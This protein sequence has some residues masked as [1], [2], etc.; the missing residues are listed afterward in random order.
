MIAQIHTCECLAWCLL[1]FQ[2]WKKSHKHISRLSVQTPSTAL[3]C[4]PLLSLRFRA[5]NIHACSSLHFWPLDRYGIV[6][7]G[8][9]KKLHLGLSRQKRAFRSWEGSEPWRHPPW[10]SY[11]LNY[12]ST[13]WTFGMQQPLPSTA[14]LRNGTPWQLAVC[15]SGLQLQ[16][17]PYTAVTVPS[18]FL[19]EEWEKLLL[20]L[21]KILIR[22]LWFYVFLSCSLL[23]F[24]LEFSSFSLFYFIPL[25]DYQG[26]FSDYSWIFLHF[27]TYLNIYYSSLRVYQ[28]GE[29]LRNKIIN[30]CYF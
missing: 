15:C 1:H 16:N 24:S 20:A 28:Q 30:H 8:L 19:T 25:T 27:I 3:P 7:H 17:L 10:G 5:V 29:C 18:F 14:A 26:L 21:R 9:P 22:L 11:P 13:R 6:L 4:S 23:F 2:V 12:P